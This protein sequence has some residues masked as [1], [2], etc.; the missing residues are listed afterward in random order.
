MSGI[1]E[2]VVQNPDLR[3]SVPLRDYMWAINEWNL[4]ESNPTVV[5]ALF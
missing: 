3:R 1:F 2:V 5:W 4:I